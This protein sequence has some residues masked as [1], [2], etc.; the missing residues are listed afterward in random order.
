MAALNVA[1]VVVAKVE[2]FLLDH[3]QPVQLSL[4]IS[5]LLGVDGGCQFTVGDFCEFRTLVIILQLGT[6]LRVI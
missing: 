4:I 6:L 1:H 2:A 3:P 5:N